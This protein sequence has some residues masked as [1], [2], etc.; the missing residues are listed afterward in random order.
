MTISGLDKLLA[1]LIALALHLFVALVFIQRP[2]EQGAV[3]EGE[4][5][6]SVGLGMAGAYTDAHK[7][8]VAKP[9][10]EP[11]KPVKPKQ[12][13]KP[14]PKSQPKPQPKSQP[15]AKVAVPVKAKTKVDIVSRKL[16][17]ITTAPPKTA[18]KPTAKLIKTLENNPK[19]PPSKAMKRASGS[20]KSRHSGGRP[21]DIQGYFAELM[22]WLNQ[23]KDYPAALKKAKQQGTVLIK[24]T[25]NKDGQ[26]LN[27]KIQTSSG[28]T[29]LDQA[30]LD[31]LAKANP[32]PAIPTSLK[33]EK[34][35]LA[36]PVDYSLRTK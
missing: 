1:L 29:A 30:A 6:I 36:I 21:G 24:F 27:S 19:A 17:T 15:V 33:R 25:I 18:A 31:M 16:Q 10:P 28:I 8:E 3:G 9:Q 32:L 20:G 5:G 7:V 35:T 11:L 2:A 26:V 14:Q 13:P 34:L 12:R 22:A 4:G 23:Y